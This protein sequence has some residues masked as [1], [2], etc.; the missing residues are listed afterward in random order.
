MPA[1][2]YNTCREIRTLARLVR[3]RAKTFD[4]SIDSTTGVVTSG[5]S[6]FLLAQFFNEAQDSIQALIT[7][8][9]PLFFQKT[10]TFT[11]TTADSYTLP[12]NTFNGSK[13]TQVEYS[14][15]GSTQNFRPL[16]QRSIFER[17]GE[18][19]NRP[20]YY[21]LYNNQII[22]NPVPSGNSG[23]GSIRVTYYESL[24]R[25]AFP[26]SS[27]AAS[28]ID[29]SNNLTALT[30]SIVAGS[31]YNLDLT[32]ISLGA[33]EAGYLCV[34]SFF[35]DVRARNITYL[36]FATGTGVVTLSP[37]SQPLDT[38]ESVP[39]SAPVTVGRDTTQFSTLPVECERYLIA[40]A[41]KRMMDQNSSDGSVSE[42]SEVRN[43]A[44]EIISN[45]S[46]ITADIESIPILDP[47]IGDQ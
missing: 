5:I 20:L 9:F 21:I 32:E 10:Y 14:V 44:D 25:L 47:Y 15:D 37:G 7:K 11:I 8:S 26:V 19:S 24:D 18:Q 41:A 46:P 28:T 43:I 42:D 23:S 1:L 13:V 45:F 4:N 17:T 6:N 12:G 27:V 36:A 40:F 16:Q 3:E 29:G 38:G 22:L 2:R 39:V 31:S 33:S 30:L 35:G 34:R